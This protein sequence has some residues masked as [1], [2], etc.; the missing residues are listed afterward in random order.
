M[1]LSLFDNSPIDIDASIE[2]HCEKDAET[3]CRKIS[4][5]NPRIEDAAV[6]SEV[7]MDAKQFREW[8]LA[9]ARKRFRDRERLAGRN[10]SEWDEG[11]IFHILK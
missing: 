8:Q 3:G 7:S 4:G 6:V 9:R 1:H 2:F 5:E 10:R 11:I